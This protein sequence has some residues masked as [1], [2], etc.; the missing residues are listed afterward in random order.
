MSSKHSSRPDALRIVGIDHRGLVLITVKAD[1][2]A[3]ILVEKSVV[4]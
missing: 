1:D 2:V 4:V 3:L